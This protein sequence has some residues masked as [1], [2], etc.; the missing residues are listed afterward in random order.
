MEDEK[1][2][3][4]KDIAIFQ[5][6]GESARSGFERGKEHMDD[7]KLFDTGIHILK[8]LL[9]R[10]NQEDCDTIKFWQEGGQVPQNS[11]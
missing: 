9:E 4:P 6:L 8:H 10:H 3:D 2:R 7:R 1:G 11:L 5:Y